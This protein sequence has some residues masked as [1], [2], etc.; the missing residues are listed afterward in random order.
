MQNRDGP[1][2]DQKAR[3]Q[4]PYQPADLCRQNDRLDKGITY[5]QSCRNRSRAAGLCARLSRLHPR[6][7]A[8][9]AYAEAMTEVG[10][11]NNDIGA[12]VTCFGPEFDKQRSHPE[13]SPS[14]AA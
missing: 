6:E 3:R 5:A 12:T 2:P 13:S 10:A 1:Q 8:I 7:L 14:T 11:Q 4:R 9:E